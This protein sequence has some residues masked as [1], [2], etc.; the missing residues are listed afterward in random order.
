M[1]LKSVLTAVVGT[2]LLLG[3]N[4][5]HSTSKE[6]LPVQRMLDSN[7]NVIP[8]PVRFEQHNSSKPF[9][10]N[11]KTDIVADNGLESEVNYLQL[12]INKAFALSKNSKANR[13]E[14]KIDKSLAK[15]A[16]KMTV[17][18]ERITIVGGDSA[19]VFYGIQTLR[20]MM[21]V[22]LAF[23]EIDKQA[24]GAE[25]I[26]ANIEDKPLTKWRG[27]MVDSARHFQ[28]KEFIKKFIDLMSIHKLNRMHWHLVDSEG[29]R[30]EIKKYPKL[31]EVCES[32]PAEYPSEDPTDKTRPARYMYGHFHGG[33]Y[34]TQD[35]I[36]EIVAYAKKRHVTIVPELAFP[37]HA[38][39]M[40]TAYPEFST[41]GKKPEV[42]SNISP[43]LVNVNEKSLNFL[44]D[45]LDEIMALFPSDVIHFGG[46]EAPKGQWK[47]SA[48]VQD[49]IQKAGLKDEEQLQAW[50][51]NEM[52]KHIAQKGRRP[53]GWEEIMHG[54]NMEVLTKR[55][56]VMP[57]LSVRNGVKS[58]NNGYGVIHTSVGPFYL[59]SW[60]TKSLA[61]NWAL[62]RGPLTLARIYN[63]N[64]FPGGLTK[65]GRSNIWGAQCQ[66]W[67]ELMPRTEHMEYQAYPR[68]TALA[69]LTW[70]Q[71]ENK[72]YQN[73]YQ[74]LLFHTKRLDAMKVNYRFVDPLPLTTWNKQA[75]QKQLV[76][77]IP[78]SELSEAT[79]KVAIELRSTNRKPLRV[80]KVEIINGGKVFSV[81]EHLG[82][83][84]SNGLDNAYT[85]NLPAKS[86]STETK[87]KVY[88]QPTHGSTGEIRI[89][90]GR[91]RELFN[92]R[93]FAGGDYPTAS[94]KKSDIKAAK[95][96]VRI[97]MDGLI[98]KAGNYE[99]IFKL[100]QNDAIVKIESLR[101]SGSEGEISKSAN[102]GKL[103]KSGDLLI[104]PL[105]VPKTAVKPGNS[106]FL[107]VNSSKPSGGE[108]RVRALTQWPA[109]G[110]NGWIWTPEILKGSNTATYIYNVKAL[111]DGVLDVNFRYTAGSHGLDIFNVQLVQNG[112]IITQDSHKGFTGGRPKNND[113]VLKSTTI[114]AGSN[115]QLRLSVNG[116]GGTNSHGIMTVR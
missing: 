1:R 69:E 106:I 88:Y 2:G 41:T 116:A 87:L 76:A 81:D 18:A 42:R 47:K 21:P 93:N 23:G 114:K 91:G 110:N 46:D 5:I 68:L 12:M 78:A 107:S 105:E 99:L 64:L 9:L 70:T 109:K 86:A 62:Y 49:K 57:W 43:A 33:G 14:L 92:P 101:I 10:I 17:N 104:L 108:V 38:M 97:P 29:W 96:T 53:A 60:Q 83:T 63:Y 20:Q 11:A 7:H 112:Q 98:K 79:E 37:A 85:V 94:W 4:S 3:C 73:Y 48:Y 82:K 65:E 36:R 103:A 66:L 44:R 100:N 32:F 8:R 15:E 95:H 61:D 52:A 71:L 77:S 67:S 25:V 80:S 56:I 51:F 28:P 26:A 24:E 27:V 6:L 72:N 115:Y 54:L 39:A 31:T 59:D 58:A 111:R 89:F 50:L 40:L 34:H 75:H 16:Y 30:L 22:K 74:R 55:A 19:G 13:I 45:I 84:N 113:Y 90:K 35:D 102:T